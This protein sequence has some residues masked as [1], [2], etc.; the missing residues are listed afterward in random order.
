MVLIDFDQDGFVA[1]ENEC[2]PG[3]D[4]VDDDAS[5]FP[6]AEEVCGDGIDNN[7]NG[8]VD[9]NCC[10]YFTV[11]TLV[12]ISADFQFYYDYTS[13]SCPA[14]FDQVGF[15]SNGGCSNGGYGLRVTSPGNITSALVFPTDCSSLFTITDVNE[16]NQCSTVIQAAQDV[17]QKPLVCGDSGLRS[18]QETTPFTESTNSNE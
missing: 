8:E 14:Q 2:V 3:G 13:Q 15:N 17:L 6:G 16:I 11:E 4:C 1:A 10:P 12:A 5:I 9:E 18:E 7:C